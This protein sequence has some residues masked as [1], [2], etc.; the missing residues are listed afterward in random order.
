MKTISIPNTNWNV[1][2]LII[3]GYKYKVENSLLVS[4]EVASKMTVKKLMKILKD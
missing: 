4:V 3:L 2:G 1:N